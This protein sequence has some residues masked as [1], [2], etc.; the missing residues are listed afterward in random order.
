MDQG[1]IRQG[2]GKRLQKMDLGRIADGMC[3]PSWVSLLP[4]L[5]TFVKIGISSLS[6]N[7]F[8]VLE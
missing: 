5:K 3:I 6:Y 2:L 1:S 8:Y 7:I 4:L